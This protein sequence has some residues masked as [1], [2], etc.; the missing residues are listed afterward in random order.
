[1]SEIV[2]KNCTLFLIQR[3]YKRHW[4]FRMIREPLVLCMRILAWWN[5]I[6][7][8]KHAVERAECR[9]C[10]RFMKTELEEKSATFRFFDKRI[11]SHFKTLRDSMLQPEEFR[12]AKRIA[13]E[14]TT[15]IQSSPEQRAY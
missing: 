12:E 11:G 9:G 4:W 1:V 5:G 15:K 8:R 6:D 13:A 2:C 14:S 10:V 3:C 7:A